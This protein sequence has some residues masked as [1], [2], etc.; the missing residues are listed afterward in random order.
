MLK[1]ARF[2]TPCSFCRNIFAVMHFYAS[3]HTFFLLS[4]LE[5]LVESPP[6][7][8]AQAQKVGFGQPGF[9]CSMQYYIQGGQAQQQAARH[10]YSF[11][12]SFGTNS[13]RRVMPKPSAMRCK[14]RREGFAFPLSNLLISPCAIPVRSESFFWVNPDLRLASMI[15]WIKACSGCKSSYSF[16]KSGSCNCSCR[17]S[18]NFTLN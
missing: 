13:S 18:S 10:A 8:V 9:L 16:L 11:F 7:T 1:A 2:S 14:V 4:P 5:Y 3:V 15:D 17:K 6:K 12:T